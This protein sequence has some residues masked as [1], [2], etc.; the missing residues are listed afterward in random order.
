MQEF[1]NTFI[2][3]KS[4]WGEALLEHVQISLIAILISIFIALPLAIIVSSHKKTSNIVTQVASVFQTLPSLAILGL[5]IPFVGIG[6]TPAIIALVLYGVFPILQNAVVALQ[7]IDPSL[8][9]AA[10]AFGMTKWEKL[11]KFELALAMPT[12]MSGVKTSAV[13]IVGTATLAA[14]IGAG[15]LGSF[16]MLGIDRHDSSLILIGA[17]SS[18]L[19]AIL[20][21]ILLSG[22]RKWKLKNIALLLV[23][24]VVV[25]TASLLPYQTSSSKREIVIA[26]KLGSEPD[27]LI[28]MYELLIEENSD[29]EVQ[30]KPNFGTT[31]FLYE[32]LKSGDIDIYPE[33]TGTVVYSLLKDVPKVSNDARQVY[34]V[35]RDNISKQD[36]L[37]FLEPM[38][39]FNNYGI[40]V[41]R[42]F[43]EKNSLKTISDLS[44][45]SSRNTGFTLEF[46]DRPDGTKGLES[47]YNLKFDVKTMNYSLLYSAIKSNEV[48]I[49]EIYT[50]DS[51]LK[52][53]DMIELKD[54]KQFFPPYQGAPLLKESLL[55][56][57]PEIKSI[58]NKLAGKIST[59]EMIQ[60]NYEVSV[61][62]KSA[63]DVARE[64]LKKEGLIQ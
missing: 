36:N 14:L 21:H 45:L 10:E 61:N 4:E 47:A 5:L 38:A 2:E 53:N 58:L 20:F 44:K 48:D 54:D 50:T 26:G 12:I 13:M 28:N 8:E 31:S 51:Q 37:A 15:G 60:M 35:A 16:I 1:I 49:I 25:L 62:K 40:G 19:L 9:E 6:R 7:N 41:K 52:E 63:Q 42:S 11:K 33:F 55:E 57:Y 34:E 22:I 18:A 39:Y 59:E 3:K 29:I 24:A 32:A 30:L 23:S 64:Y 17:L 46:N 56:E 27:I 43:A